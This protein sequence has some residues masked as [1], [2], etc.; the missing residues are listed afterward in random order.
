MSPT[1][2]QHYVN[3]AFNFVGKKEGLALFE[4]LGGRVKRGKWIFSGG[5]EDFLKV[6][7]NC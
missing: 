5:P 3:T 6:I 4:F 2:L 1:C 7:F